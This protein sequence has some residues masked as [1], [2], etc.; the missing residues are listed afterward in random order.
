MF[1]GVASPRSAADLVCHRLSISG[2]LQPA[3]LL[4]GFVEEPHKILPYIC[5][6]DTGASGIMKT[7]L[8]RPLH[9]S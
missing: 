4:V 1:Y 2:L 7:V 8:N 3:V 6:V 9:D 5:G